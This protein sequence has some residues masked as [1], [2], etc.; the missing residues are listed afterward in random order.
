MWVVLGSTMLATDSKSTKTEFT[1]DV[2]CGMPHQAA[3]AMCIFLQSGELHSDPEP[4]SR[5]GNLSDG[6][7]KSTAIHPA[8]VLGVVPGIARLDVVPV[9]GNE[10]R[11]AQLDGKRC[12]R[13][14]IQLLSS[15][16]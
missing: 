2:Q 3:K 1:V 11:A 5:S 7:N 6:R 12:R 14:H 16:G 4:E 15:C 9:P 13:M 10:T 8:D